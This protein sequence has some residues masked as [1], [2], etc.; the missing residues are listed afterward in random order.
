MNFILKHDLLTKIKAQ[1]LAILTEDTQNPDEELL[2]SISAAESELKGYITHRHDVDIVM[3]PIWYFN[4]SNERALNDLIVLYTENVYDEAV[5]YSLNDLVVVITETE[6]RV[7]RSDTSVNIGNNPLSGAP[8]VYVGTNLT[9]Y[10]SLIDD[11]D[12]D[13]I[14]GTSW[15]K[16]AVDPR[17]ALLK[18][19]LI[20]LV[21]YDLHAR[22]KP[23]QIPEH[24]VQLRDDAIKF[25]RDAADPRKNITLNLPLVDHGTKSGV[26]LTFGGNQKITHSY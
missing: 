9:F 26:D 1:E 24:R 25:L 19:L 10:K 7:Y 4:T 18:S 13:P 20:N 3:P 14:T 17:D 15:V 5:K 6:K 12:D 2:T 22:I 21:L 8:W 23:R 16:L 11:N